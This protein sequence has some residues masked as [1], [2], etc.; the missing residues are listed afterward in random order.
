MSGTGASFFAIRSSLDNFTSDIGSPTATGATINLSGAAFQNIASSITFRIYGW[1]ASAS[2]GTF[3]INDFTFNGT[4]ASTILDRNQV[5]F[6]RPLSVRQQTAT[7][8]S[9]HGRMP[10]VLHHRTDIL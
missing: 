4:V 8:F 7:Q 10:L 1:G 2:G 5:I 3:S 9:N 6:P